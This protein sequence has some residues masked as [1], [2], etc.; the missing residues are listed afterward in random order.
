VPTA[1]EQVRSSLAVVTAAA[2]ADV[3]TV[4]TA[5][6]SQSPTVVRDSLFAAVPLIVADYAD[7]AATLGLDWFEELRDA[8]RPSK[9]YRAAPFPGVDPEQLATS[10]AWATSGLHD[11]EREF[12]RLVDADAEKMLAQA[13]DEAMTLLLPDVQKAVADGFRSTVTTNSERDPAAAGWRRFARADGCKFCQM[14]AA[15]GAVYRESTVHFAAHTDCHCVVGP[16]YDPNAP[17]ADVMQ[18]VASSRTRSPEQQAA[19]REYL[20]QHYPDAPG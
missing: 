3:Q 10:V 19:L 15:R 5:A 18:Y 20:N 12:S 6:S 7:G 1:P 2:R 16:S 8:A 9:P 11:L 17:H 13:T 14:L 4:A